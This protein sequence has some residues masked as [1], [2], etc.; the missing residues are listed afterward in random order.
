MFEGP[1]PTV[2]LNSNRLLLRG[3]PLPAL[4]MIVLDRFFRGFHHLVYLSKSQVGHSTLPITSHLGCFETSA[5]LVELARG[6]EPS[7]RRRVGP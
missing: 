5:E 4:I 7:N 6:I 1:P 3:S 2:Q